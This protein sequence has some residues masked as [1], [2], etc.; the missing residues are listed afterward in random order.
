M[1]EKR[2]KMWSSMNNI[3]L[4][5]YWDGERKRIQRLRSKKR[6]EASPNIADHEQSYSPSKLYNTRQSFGKAVRKA[7]RQLLDSPR[8]KPL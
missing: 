5:M 4:K 7:K 2:E 3:Q 1:K 8:K 6:S